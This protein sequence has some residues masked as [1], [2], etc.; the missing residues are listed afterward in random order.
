M[1]GDEQWQKSQKGTHTRTMRRR[2]RAGTIA[3][4]RHRVIGV[5]SILG[6]CFPITRTAGGFA[7]KSVLRPTTGWNYENA[8]A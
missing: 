5:G 4:A 6:F 3:A 8:K 2:A 1:G 7:T